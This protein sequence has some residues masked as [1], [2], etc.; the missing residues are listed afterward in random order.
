[1]KPH[2][3]HDPVYIGALGMDGI[4]VEAENIPNFVEKFWLLTS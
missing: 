2:E 1:V 4:M 3:P